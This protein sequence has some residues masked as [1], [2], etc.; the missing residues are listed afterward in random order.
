MLNL[1]CWTLD[2]ISDGPIEGLVD[3][4][5]KILDDKNLSKGI[6]LDDTAIS[7][8][9]GDVE[10]DYDL[11]LSEKKKILLNTNVFSS[12]PKLAGAVQYSD[13]PV[14]LVGGVY[15]TGGKERVIIYNWEKIYRSLDNEVAE[16]TWVQGSVRSSNSGLETHLA[17][18]KVSGSFK[19]LR[20]EGGVQP[21]LG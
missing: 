15:Q 13:F 16:S 9:S 14:R 6:Y 18:N 3:S 2:L 19:G 21:F 11:S 8:S 10:I 4:E 17:Y 1:R 7:V 20:Q 12:L 5:G